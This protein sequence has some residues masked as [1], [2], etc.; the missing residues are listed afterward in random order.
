M[1]SYH[2]QQHSRTIQRQNNPTTRRSKTRSAKRVCLHHHQQRSSAAIPM[3]KEFSQ[4]TE[5]FIRIA[6]HHQVCELAFILSGADIYAPDSFLLDRYIPTTTSAVGLSP[7]TTPNCSPRQLLYTLNYDQKTPGKK[8]RK[9]WSHTA[10]A[11]SL[12]SPSLCC[13][14]CE[15]KC[16]VQSGSGR[17]ERTNTSKQRASVVEKDWTLCFGPS[18]SWENSHQKRTRHRKTLTTAAVCVCSVLHTI[19]TLEFKYGRSL[20]SSTARQKSCQSGPPWIFTLYA[21]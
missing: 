1:N 6:R 17:G 4:N 21:R 16:G 5:A 8:E 10:Q 18:D 7:A 20:N 9:R 19:H 15:G 13:L 2:A 14:E 12:Q 11:A 3:K